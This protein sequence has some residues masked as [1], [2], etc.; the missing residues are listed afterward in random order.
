MES[1]NALIAGEYHQG[2]YPPLIISVA[3]TGAVPSKEKYPNLPVTP[4]DIARDALACA[5]LGAQIF[6]IH[7]RDDAGNPSQDV[8][9]F[10]ETIEYIRSEN[11][12]LVIC[13]TTTSRGSSSLEDR[14][15]PLKLPDDALPDMVSL[16]LGSYN[17]PFGINAN[18]QE[19][20]LAIAEAARE[21]GVAIE[22]EV[23][24]LGMLSTYCRLVESGQVHGASILNVLLGVQGALPATAG[25]LTDAV[26]NMPAGVEWAAAG[27]GHFQGPINLMAIAMGGNVRVGMEDDPRGA[28]ENWRNEDAVQR[29]LDFAR[30]SGRRLATSD[31]VRSR[32]GLGSTGLSR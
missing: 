28:R 11:D 10:R 29:A 21:R 25:A 1:G 22:G 20:L 32:L 31:E 26:R 24:E 18:P 19:D 8:R 5:A 4:K 17:T 27:I 14:L 30:L 3:L 9:K 16:S 2:N 15:V 7:M 23:F 12:G 6:H 13:A